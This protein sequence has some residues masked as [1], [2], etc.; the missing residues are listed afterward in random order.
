M[1][2][3]LLI[4]PFGIGDVLFTTPV[5][6]AIRDSYPDGSIGYWCNERVKDILKD[7]KNID[8][9]FALSRGD[10]K[11]MYRQSRLKGIY[12]FFSLLRSIKKHRFDI[13]VDFSLDHRY[14][15]LA[16]IL[17]IKKADRLQL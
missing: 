4:N 3:F 14:S 13:A 6:R 12:R 8:F 11:R 9:V 7:N 5:I 10:I 2:K 17:G 15:L 1:K 16:K